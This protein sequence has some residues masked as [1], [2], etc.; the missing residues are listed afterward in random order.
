MARCSTSA[1]TCM[2][3]PSSPSRGCTHKMPASAAASASRVSRGA[4]ASGRSATRS[5][6]TESQNAPAVPRA[7]CKLDA[8]SALASSAISA[9]RSPVLI[10]RQVSTAFRAPGSRSRECDPNTDLVTLPSALC[11]LPFA[12]CLLPSALR[13]NA[14]YLPLRTP[15]PDRRPRSRWRDPWRST[16]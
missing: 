9:T 7:S 15:A 14:F 13:I 3:A 4:R 12:L 1:T 8:T 6:R 16:G 5:S 2:R 11:P 10:A